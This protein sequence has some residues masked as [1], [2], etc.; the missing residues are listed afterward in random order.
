MMGPESTSSSTPS[1]NGKRG[2]DPEDEVYLDN[3]RSHKRYLSEIMASSLNG[4]TVGDPLPEYLLESPARS[5]GMFY[6]RDE[7]P[8]QY[9]PMSE[10][11]DDSRFS[12]TA[13]NTCFPHS[14]RLPTSPVSPY[15]YQRPLN[16]FYSTP[17][18]SSYS[19][20]GNVSAVTCSQP[21]KRGSD[22]EGQFPSSPSDIC[23]SADLRRAAL[24]RSVHMKTQPA[25]SS[26]LELQFGLGQE[27]SLSIEAEERP[28]SFVK[29]LIGDS[30]YQTEECSS[31]SIS[32]PEFSREKSCGVSN[33]DLKG[34]ESRA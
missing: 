18:T 10:D 29:S 32:E 2:R 15:R 22:T 4:L 13:M 11:S 25:G 7:M 27:N 20:P 8:C 33:M 28:C 31:T 5:E 26:S 34:D 6:P 24:M 17:S 16:A 3:L 1:P 30:E 21:R 19:L 12:E 14:D 23:H 9:S